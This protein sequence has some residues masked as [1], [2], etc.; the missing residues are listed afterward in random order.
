[1]SATEPA[2]AAPATG[3]AD[4]IAALEA[5]VARLQRLIDATAGAVAAT[6]AATRE[7]CA[8]A[9]EGMQGTGNALE[10]QARAAEMLRAD[11]SLIG[12]ATP[13]APSSP[14]L[15]LDCESNEVALPAETPFVPFGQAMDTICAFFPDALAPLVVPPGTRYARILDTTR[16]NLGA[17]VAKRVQMA[18][19]FA[20]FPNG[21]WQ[22]VCAW[23]RRGA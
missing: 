5:E 20:R 9:I 10:F 11:A 1:M 8:D 16:G 15:I 14:L 3:Q 17:L 19:G 12:T 22:Q 2:S 18:H 21:T 4:R 6:E 7:A 23:Q 13:T